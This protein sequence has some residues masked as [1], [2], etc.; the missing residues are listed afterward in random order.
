MIGFAEVPVRFPD[1]QQNVNTPPES[2]IAKGFIPETAYARGQGLPAQWLNW[3]FKTVFR[4]INRDVVTDKSGLNLFAIPNC[5]IRLEAVDLDA[6]TKYL[7]A[8]GFTKDDGTHQL[9]AVSSNGL[10][11]GTPIAKT[12]QPVV[13]GNNLIVTGYSRQLGGV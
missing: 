4:A 7:I 1:G 3:L 2:I 9:T 11:L 10:S 12:D 5:S 8:I 13:G 6:P